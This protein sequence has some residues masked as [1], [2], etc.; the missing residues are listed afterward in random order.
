MGRQVKARWAWVRFLASTLMALDLR[1]YILSQPLATGLAQKEA[2]FY[3]A[4]SY[5]GRQAVEGAIALGPCLDW[6]LMAR[7]SRTYIVFRNFLLLTTTGHTHL[8]V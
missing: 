8:G 1:P 2:C 7:A 6:A 4:T 5:T 3:R